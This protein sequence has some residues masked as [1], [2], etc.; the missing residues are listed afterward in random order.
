MR[1][2]SWF[3]LLCLLA[4][5]VPAGVLFTGCGDDDGGGSPKLITVSDFEGSWLAA[6]YKLTSSANS[7]ISLDLVESGGAFS[8]D[9]D[10]AGQF[11]GRGFIPASLA[12]VSLE[13]EFQGAFDLI[14]Q[15]SVEVNFTPEFPPFLED[16]RAG[17]TLVGE[18]FTIIDENTL[19]DFDGDQTPEPA[20]FEGTM[21]RH[22]TR[23]PSVIFVSD[24]EGYWEVTSYKVTSVASPDTSMDAVAMGATFGFDLDEDGQ[25]L[26]D[27]FI[28]EALAGQDIVISDSPGY[29]YL[30]T[31]DTVQVAFTPE[32]PPFL[33]DFTGAFTMDAD[34]MSVIDE[35][36][37]FDFD[38]DQVEEAAIFEGTMVRT[39]P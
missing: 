27:A 1:F 31:Q 23:G 6:S 34:T 15:D 36:A 14:T 22:D 2:S 9:A 37:T 10:D 12:G 16:T 29:F 33:T 3:G 32:I 25:F 38:G 18:T 20:I 21:I 30:V 8:W 24:F 19:F 28:P 11:S 7:Q 4:V 26:G 35:N 5:V 13:L 17:F 39:S